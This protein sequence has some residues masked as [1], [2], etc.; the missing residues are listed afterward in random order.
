[1]AMCYTSLTLNMLGT[2][3]TITLAALMLLFHPVGN[4]KARELVK[5]ILHKVCKCC[6]KKD[7]N[8]VVPTK[9]IFPTTPNG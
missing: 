9:V 2:V 8:A 6:Y 7:T 4:A 1:M 5:K 3:L